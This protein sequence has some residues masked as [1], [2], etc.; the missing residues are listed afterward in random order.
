MTLVFSFVALLF[1]YALISGRL[2]RSVLTAPMIFT[3]TGL[4]LGE[5][6]SGLLRQP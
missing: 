4:A 3:A 2:E 6:I 1:V 5:F